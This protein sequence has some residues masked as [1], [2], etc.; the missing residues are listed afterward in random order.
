M[1]KLVLTLAFAACFTLATVL[2]AR[3]RDLQTQTDE[4]NGV[5]AA[6]MGD[7]RRMFANQLF[8]E[9]DVY[10]HS[11][12]YPTMFDKQETDIDV[13]GDSAG[14]QKGKPAGTADVEE[15]FLGQFPPGLDS[16]LLGGIFLS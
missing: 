13:K 8:I 6:I 10:F 11:G 15:S 1:I 4:S 14:D 7:S 3:L 5:V 2:D 9:A 12:Y 16:K